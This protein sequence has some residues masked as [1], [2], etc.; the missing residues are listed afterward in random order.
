[1]RSPNTIL[2]PLLLFIFF[3]GC[4]LLLP[5][6]SFAQRQ[7][8]CYTCSDTQ[9]DLPDSRSIL[10]I[11]R[12]RGSRVPLRQTRHVR[13][14][15]R[16]SS[17]SFIMNE[18][19]GP[20]RPSDRDRFYGVG[21]LEVGVNLG[22]AFAYTDINGKPGLDPF[23][24]D[25]LIQNNTSLTAGLFARYRI[26]E[27]FGFSVGADMTRLRASNPNGFNHQY[28]VFRD[29]NQNETLENVDVYSFSNDLAELSGK[30]ELYSPVIGRSSLSVYGFAGF[31]VI[32]HN[33][34][35]YDSLGQ[36]I[37][38]DPLIIEVSNPLREI[39]PEP[40]P[41]MAY[42]LPFGGGVSVMMANFVRVGLEVGYRYTGSHGL[43]GLH[44]SE[45][46]YDSYVFTTIRIGYVFPLRK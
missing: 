45:N 36:P 27:W 44:I 1:M 17:L 28:V 9:V 23:E 31:S 13:V 22:T 16:R 25:Q 4:L 34:S 18:P 8:D 42:A 40:A 29:V 41:N 12:R 21:A 35:I 38:L 10:R 15:D 30:L 2:L 46:P 14:P 32:L 26:N 37:T 20:I 19:R 33:P 3:V 6:P 43:D 39:E 5:G 7:K 11:N 24:L